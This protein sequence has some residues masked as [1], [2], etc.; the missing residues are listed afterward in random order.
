ME[1]YGNHLKMHE[2]MHKEMKLVPKYK[3]TCKKI[4]IV[5]TD[6]DFYQLVDDRI[7]VWSPIKKKMYEI[8]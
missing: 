2:V 6:R 1:A 5:S 4:T 3:E 8:L 7:Q